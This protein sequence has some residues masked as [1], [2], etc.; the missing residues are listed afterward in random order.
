MY[1]G[2]KM[3]RSDKK[4]KKPLKTKQIGFP[5][6]VHIASRFVRVSPLY[7]E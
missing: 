2:A 7:F 6:R 5:Y 3:I 4:I 1:N